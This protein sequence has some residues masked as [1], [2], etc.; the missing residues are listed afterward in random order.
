[1]EVSIKNNSSQEISFSPFAAIPIFA[2]AL[3]N[4]HDHEHVTALLHRIEQ[5]DEG[6][7]V[8]PVMRFNEEGH[9]ENH[10]VYFVLG[11]CS[12]KSAQLGSF[13]TVDSFLGDEGTLLT[14]QAVKNNLRPKR[15]DPSMLN[16]KEAFGALRFKDHVL[17]PQEEI[18]YFLFIGSAA[19]KEVMLTTFNKFSSKIA[20]DKALKEN[21]QYW[22]DKAHAISF[23]LGDPEVNSWLQWSSLQPVFRR[24][25]GCSFLPDHDYGKGGKGWRDIWQD[26]LSL[27]LIEP[28]LVRD[29]LVN[30]FAGV[31]ID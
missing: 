11:F 6:V 15:L 13:P 26:L 17:K 18:S 3:A 22:F 20:F 16:G 5:I 21:Q 29:R 8:S 30:N 31:R 23:H 25:F 27:I 14:V 19:N 24:I 28:H 1:M 9:K 7:V 4:K 2:R 12:L 10:Q